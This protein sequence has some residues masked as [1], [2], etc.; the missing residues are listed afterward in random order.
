MHKTN[1]LTRLVSA[2]YRYQLTYL[3]RKLTPYNLGGGS[4]IFLI[5]IYENPGIT[6]TELSTRLLIDRATVSKMLA[7][8]ENQGLIRRSP[9][10]EDGRAILLEI[11][12]KGTKISKCLFEITAE[13]RSLALN[14][15]SPEEY[16]AAVT[17]LEKILS[18]IQNGLAEEKSRK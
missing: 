2:V 16:D 13:Y 12:P 7:H 3:N 4:Y 11:T 17:I 14:G 9:N 5:Y 15:I 18:N 6:Q 10:P 1:P 8:L